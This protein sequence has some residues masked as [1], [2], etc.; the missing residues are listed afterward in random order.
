MPRHSRS[1][2]MPCR[3]NN[4]ITLNSVWL[5]VR[6]VLCD[7]DGC[8]SAVRLVLHRCGSIACGQ[9]AISVPPSSA[10]CPA[11]KMRCAR[12]HF[13]HR[14]LPEALEH[15]A[16]T[17][18][19]PA[20]AASGVTAQ[21]VVP[22]IL[23]HCPQWPLAQ[24]GCRS[25]SAHQ[26]HPAASSSAYLAQRTCADMGDQLR[27]A[28]PQSASHCRAPHP[29]CHQ[30]RVAHA[31][32][33]CRLLACARI[34]HIKVKH[35]G[36]QS[37]PTEFSGDNA[38]M[39][40]RAPMVVFRK[41][42]HRRRHWLADRFLALHLI[43]AGGRTHTA[44]RVHLQTEVWCSGARTP[45]SW[46]KIAAAAAMRL[47]LLMYTPP[48]HAALPQRRRGDTVS[49]HPSISYDCSWHSLRVIAIQSVVPKPSKRGADA[50]I[51]QSF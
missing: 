29:Q 7:T 21:A 3:A 37:T 17:R 9:H 41:L 47:Q 34:L 35:V 33:A 40:A 51:Q 15:Y 22:R 49:P 31:P 24:W 10:C 27:G 44:S 32:V 1:E 30:L 46:L 16:C 23:Q 2:R 48:P 50:T 36:S 12:P 28:P 14:C 19:H 11:A 38:T 26:N 4:S 39:A 43:R 13:S 25:A 45:F 5:P 42:H 20:S 8:C 6:L 18:H